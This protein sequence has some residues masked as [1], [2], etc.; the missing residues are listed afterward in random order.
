[1]VQILVAIKLGTDPVVPLPRAAFHRTLEE[2]LYCPKCDATYSLLADYDWA[3]SRHFRDDVRMH[4]SLLKRALLRG[5]STDHRI[6][7]FESNGVT[8]SAHQKPEPPGVQAIA[9]KHIM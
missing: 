5:H 6:T 3:V 4:I 8:V 2:Y 9:V 1:M 7:H